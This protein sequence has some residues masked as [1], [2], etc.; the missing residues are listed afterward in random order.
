MSKDIDWTAKIP[1]HV[2][3]SARTHMSSADMKKYVIFSEHTKGTTGKV[4]R[5]KADLLTRFLAIV[6]P[7][8]AF[9][10][11]APKDFIIRQIES[12]RHAAGSANGSINNVNSAFR[13]IHSVKGMNVYYSILNESGGSNSPAVFITD[14]RPSS[15]DRIGKAGLYSYSQTRN[16]YAEEKESADLS[17]K[18]VFIAGQSEDIAGSYEKAKSLN[19]TPHAI[20]Y[21]PA[22][23]VNELGVWRSPGQSLQTQ[24]AVTKLSQHMQNNAK[25][26][27]FWVA[28][29]EGAALAEQALSEVRGVLPEQKMRVIDPVADTPKLLQKLKEKQMKIG[30]D[31]SMS[32]DK[33]GNSSPAPVEYTGKRRDAGVLMKSHMQ[34]LLQELVSARTVLENRD[35]HKAEVAKLKSNVDQSEG[36]S[37]ARSELTAAGRKNLIP[38][39][40]AITF[41]DAIKRL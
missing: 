11:V 29:G 33:L 31:V 23:V 4:V 25:K 15:G 2:P 38:A 3:C 10:P 36:F 19:L 32:G 13:Y 16:R 20:F 26:K 39:I 40:A 27:V 14:V 1:S 30:S 17:G 5:I 12:L 24:D 28:E 22:N 9:N 8:V 41:V 35:A 21:C 34:A 7:Q 6:D 18:S 37:K